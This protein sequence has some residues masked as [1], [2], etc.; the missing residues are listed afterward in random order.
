MTDRID[1][2]KSLIRDVPD[3]PKPGIMFKDITPLLAHPEGFAASID[4]LAESAAA[5][6]A[7]LVAG[8]EARGFLFGLPLAQKLGVGF[9]PIRKK[10]KL[11]AK[12]VEESYELEYGTDTVQMH[13]DAIPAGSKVV[14]VD[15]L[16]ATGGTM[17]ACCRLAEKT[18]GQVVGCLF[19]IE[20]D[21]LEGR[22]KLGD[23]PVTSL[24][25]Y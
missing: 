6:G 20:L 25:H 21:F 15:D 12:T 24:I 5:M 11:P 10:G 18:G 16:L 17:G 8:P 3:F 4:L 13:E 14:L 1:L 22:P 19:A 23:V 2:I 7:D 9:V